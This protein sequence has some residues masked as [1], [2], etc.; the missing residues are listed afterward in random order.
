MNVVIYGG[1]GM[2]G[3]HVVKAL[4]G[5]VS[6]RIT[7]LEPFETPHEMMPVDVADPEAVLRA[8]EGMDAIV[9]LSVLRPHRK[10]AFDVNTLG[11]YN[12][13]RAAVRHGI[14][15]VINTGPHFTVQGESYV[16]WDYYIG[17]D[18]PPKPGTNLYAISKGLGQEICR[19]FSA[20]FDVY[21]LCFLFW[22]FRDHDPASQ[23]AQDRS[24]MV[25]WRD[26][27]DAFLPGLKIPLE[28][29]PSRCE[30]FD[31]LGDRPHGHFTNEKTRRI[32]GWRPRDGMEYTYL[33]K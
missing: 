22:S 10:I 29:L 18:V 32:L 31:I 33:K 6:L 9:N 12:V 1:N 7:D 20:N 2:L 21:V 4:E 13:M 25:T 5:R 17:P 24:F 30:V 27:A 19:V 23:P 28:R 11:C 3:P 16:D 26:A 8:A 15:R 14:R